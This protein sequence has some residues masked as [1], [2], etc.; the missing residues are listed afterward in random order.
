MLK[1]LI[2]DDHSIFRRGLKDLLADGL[3]AVTV[4][5]CSNAFDLFQLVKQ[6]KWDV[7]IF[8][9]RDHAEHAS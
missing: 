3:G 8:T 6:K 9:A 2:A 7:V 4:G 5:E 1:I